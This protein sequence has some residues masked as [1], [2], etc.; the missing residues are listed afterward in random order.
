[1][2]LPPPAPTL[3]DFYARADL[4]E[5]LPRILAAVRS[6]TVGGEYMHWDDVRRRPPPDG[7]T[8]EEWWFG[9][10]FAR[11]G[12]ARPFPLTNPGGVAFDYCLTDEALS[13]LHWIDQHGSGEILLGE[14]VPDPGDR[15]R[16]LVNSL[17]EEAITSSQLEGATSTRRVA[18]EMLR[19]GRTPRDRSERMILNNYLAMTRIRN[20]ASKPLTP[21][22]VYELHRILTERTLDDPAAAG[23]PQQPGEVRVG[24]FDAEGQRV[25][26]PPPADQLPARMEA[27]CAF[28]NGES[29]QGFVHPV[30]R[31]ILLHLW[32]AY[33]H[34]FEDGNGRTARAIF[35]WSMLRSGYWMFEYVSISRILYGAP[36]RYSRSFLYTETDEL[37]ATYFLLYQLTVL[38]RSIDELMEYL[39]RKTREVSQTVGLLRQSTLNHRQVALLTH[40]LRHSDAEY[41]VRSHS[42]SHRVTNQSARTDLLDLERL[43]M[44][45]RRQVGKRFVFSPVRDLARKVSG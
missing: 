2:K 41:T 39:R 12:L 4:N 26:T 13:V 33:D 38:R 22:V 24:V 11:R 16:Y 35:Y 44:L 17:I 18:K 27:M 15:S 29:D 32:L 37:D 42:T 30:V 21:E 45:E 8:V 10:K 28:A 40:A 5:R 6:T 20:F 23:R 19:S 9:I 31:A 7:L 43:G 1:M 14:E 34:P 3:Q 25:H 36:A